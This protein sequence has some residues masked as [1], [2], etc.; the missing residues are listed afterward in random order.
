MYSLFKSET[1][2]KIETNMS[3]N[4]K[5]FI[6]LEFLIPYFS[7][8]FNKKKKIHAVI[9]NHKVSKLNSIPDF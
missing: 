4:F 8:I 7:G 3:M 2:L 9:I 1:C 6:I 5:I